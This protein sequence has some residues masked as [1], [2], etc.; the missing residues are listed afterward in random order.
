MRFAAPVD[1]ELKRYIARLVKHQSL[2][3]A[4]INRRV[5]ERA[6]AGGARRPSYAAVRLCVLD[7]RIKL[8]D[9]SWLDLYL[10][11]AYEHESPEVLVHKALGIDTPMLRGRR[12]SGGPA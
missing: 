2:A 8:Q 9:P 3:I 1:D 7:L 10:R 6:E 11:I 12:G 5:G 4:E